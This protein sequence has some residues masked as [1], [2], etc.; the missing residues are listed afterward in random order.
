M[1][2]GKFRLKVVDADVD[3]PLGETCA[4]AITGYEMAAPLQTFWVNDSDTELEAPAGSG[5]GLTPEAR[6]FDVS[7][8]TES[9]SQSVLPVLVTL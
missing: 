5:L 6:F 4:L 9:K 1:K 8:R 7:P 2:A 3:F